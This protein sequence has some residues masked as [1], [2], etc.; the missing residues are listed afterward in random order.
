MG[1]SSRRS[2]RPRTPKNDPWNSLLR[3]LRHRPRSEYEARRR[4]ERQGFATDE[5]ERTIAQAIDAGMID[6]ALFAKLWVDDR[7]LHRPLSRRAVEVEL[8]DKGIEPGVIRAALDAAYPDSLEKELAWRLGRERY[9]RL[10]ALERDKRSRRVA[11][12]LLRKGF[13]RSL[14]I[15]VVRALEKEDTA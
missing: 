6:D 7:L 14:A 10:C 4:L 11:D 15:G 1:R 2:R 3:L 5:I 13:S 9:E 8:R 12:F